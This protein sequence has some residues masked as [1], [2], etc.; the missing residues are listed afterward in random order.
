MR[1]LVVTNLYPPYYK[2]GYELRCKDV[3]EALQGSGHEVRVLT[4]GYGLPVTPLGGFRPRAEEVSGVRVYRYLNQY[5]FRPQP[6]WRP[7]RLVRPG[8]ELADAR[9]LLRLLSSFRP[10]VVSWWSMYGLAKTLLALPGRWNIADVHWIEHWWMIREYGP[11]GE[12]VAR[13]WSDIWDGT[14]GPRLCRPLLRR[15]GRRWER[16]F[17]HAGLPTRAFPNRPRHVSFVSEYMRTLHR[18]AGLDF[19]SSEVIHGGVRTEDFY[20]PLRTKPDPAGPLRLLYAGQ[21]SRDR[22]LHTVVEAMARVSPGPRSQ[23][24][25]SV[26][27]EGSAAYLD[28]VKARVLTLALTGSIS[29]LGKVP[30]E[31]MRDLYRQHD[32]LVFPSVRQEGLPLTMVEA[33]LAGCA[34]LTTG[35]GGAMEIA[36]PAALPMFPGNDPAALASLLAGLVAQ[37]E[38]VCE[39]AERGQKTVL[40]EFAFEA[41]VDRWSATLQRVRDA[42]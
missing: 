29:F 30:R 20:E 39:I 6:V 15:W 21:L 26:A 11:A 18:E 3:A 7:G 42:E 37:Q 16:R 41:M 4:S 32:V 14:W 5:M 36:V 28:E 1:I 9:H 13:F 33:M 2:G 34:V 24:R 17:E 8:R 19:P 23:L 10:D 12:K 40:K 31:R 35:S 25:L 38:R 22:G 27:G